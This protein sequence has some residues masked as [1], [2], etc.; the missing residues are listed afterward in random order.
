MIQLESEDNDQIHAKSLNMF[1]AIM[2]A[3]DKSM[4]N[5]KSS[6]EHI[7]T[8]GAFY[9]G[10]MFALRN[11]IDQVDNEEDREHARGHC[12]DFLSKPLD[13]IAEEAESMAKKRK[14]KQL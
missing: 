14:K 8:A 11:V 7:L 13:Q 2:R 5:C 9:H 10:L 12:I 6:K 1:K 3:F 4:E